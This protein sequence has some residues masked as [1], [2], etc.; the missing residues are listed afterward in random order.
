MKLK[1]IALLFLTLLPPGQVTA[2]VPTA[3]PVIV[4]HD[5][6]H[7]NRLHEKSRNSTVKIITNMGHGS[8]TYVKIGRN[9]GI[10]TAAHVVAQGNHFIVEA[11]TRQ[12]VGTLIWKNEEADLAFLMVEKIPVIEPVRMRARNNI[13][14]GDEVVYSG[15]PSTHEMLTFSCIISNPDYQGRL[16]L[17]GFAWFGASGSGFINARGDVIAVLSAVTVE[18]FYGHPQVLETMVIGSMLTDSHI[19]EIR[20]AVDAVP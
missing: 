3:S 13:S 18:N 16:I 8:G 17:Q 11:G 1:H 15:F 2:E 4:D 19:D 9:F 14:V 7:L 6:V 20:N 12:T 5:T 10:L